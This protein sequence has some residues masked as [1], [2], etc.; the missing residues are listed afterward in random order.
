MRDQITK[1]QAEQDRTDHR[2]SALE[3]ATA[4]DRTGRLVETQPT[5]AAANPAHAGPPPRVVALGAAESPQDDDPND[6]SPRPEIRVV[7]AGGGVAHGR[8]TD[9]GRPSAL[10]PE[11]KR[12]YDAALA[13]VR[14][15]S[16]DRALE[17]LTAFLVRWPDHPYAENATYWRGET[18]YAKGEYAR[19][20][21]QF[22]AVL[23]RFGGGAK[24]P[25]A[26]LKLGMCQ[27]RLGAPDRAKELY[28]R[29]RADYPRSD[30]AKHI[31]AVARDDRSP[32]GPKETR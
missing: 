30:A 12:A 15:K 17:G 3:V 22:E 1:I 29:L 19:A 23:S 7:G 18:L 20:A 10:D 5:P 11:A 32:K 26:L 31:P 28:D 25:D 27:E 24:A 4:E 21:E 9:P 13:Q 8:R 16:Y 2:L 6:P 14:A